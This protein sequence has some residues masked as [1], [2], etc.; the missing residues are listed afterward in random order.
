MH[1]QE[2]VQVVDQARVHRGKEDEE[3]ASGTG[4]FRM[5]SHRQQ[6]W[7]VNR[8]ATKAKSTGNK[9]ADEAKPCQ[10]QEHVSAELDIPMVIVD[11]V[12]HFQLLLRLIDP[13]GD[14]GDS[15]A[16]HQEESLQVELISRAGLNADDRGT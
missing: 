8:A 7:I 5:H 2:T 4:D 13:D 1:V 10:L 12:L 15:D 9:A 6:G 11:V 14:H 16:D 3:H